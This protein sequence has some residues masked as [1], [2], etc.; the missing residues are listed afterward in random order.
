MQSVTR[1]TRFEHLIDSHSIRIGSWLYRRTRGRIT[2]LWR[3]RALI[4]TTVGRRSGRPRTVIVQ[5]FPDGDDFVVVAA[6]SGMPS[7]PG[8]YFNLTAHPEARVEVEGRTLTV[9]ATE[10]MPEEAARFWP[11]VLSI[12]PDYA[13]YRE[14]TTRV[15]PLMRLTPTA[16]EAAPTEPP[17]G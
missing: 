9:R 6:N 2:H 13:R 5:F 10:L 17:P 8:W 1:S 14:R 4:L 16:R 7:H 11:R 3:R 12:A 15:I